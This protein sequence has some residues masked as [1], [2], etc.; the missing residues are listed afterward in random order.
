MSKTQKIGLT[1]IFFAGLAVFWHFL[2]PNIPDLDSF[3]YLGKAHLIREAGLFNDSFPWTQFS[4]IKN[5]GSSLW[6]GFGLLLVPFSYIAN[7]A[8]GIKLAGVLLTVFALFSCFWVASRHKLRWPIVWPLLMFFSAPNVTIQLLMTR[9]QTATVG[10]GILLLSFLVEGR[11]WQVL[12]TTF[13]LVWIH[14]NFAWM[15]IAIAG[16]VLLARVLV[17]KRFE[18]RKNLA[19]IT[20]VFA[21]WIARPNP[22]GAAKLFY[23]QVVKQILEKQGGLPLLFGKENFP[24]TT[25]VLLTNF[26][27]FLLLWLVCLALIVWLWWRRTLQTNPAQ[28]IL[29]ISGLILS[30]IF[31]FL[32]ILIARRAYDFW[33]AFGVI[34]IAVVISQI[35]ELVA[36]Q[37]NGDALKWVGGITIVL[38]VFLTLFSGSKTIKSLPQTYSQTYL[39]ESA[40]WLNQN[41]QPGDIVFNVHWSHFSPLFLWD[42]KNYYI[43]A[44]DPIFQY[45][46]DP[47]LYWKFHYLSA[48][49]TSSFT[50]GQPACKRSEVEDTY[51]VLKNDFHAKYLLV[52]Q[53]Y[54]PNLY[55]YLPTDSRFQKVFET[56]NEAVYLIR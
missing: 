5:Y 37:K 51:T 50:C 54:N 19:V 28:K 48:D 47:T 22:L 56:M 23:V 27:P 15:P 38:L 17:E 20:G 46:Y 14:L 25:N 1:V 3:F 53:V 8:V 31:F 55:Q 12:L 2:S 30:P 39:K 40:D 18:L 42:R 4:V 10:L 49:Q 52:S 32:S 7:A 21:G 34:I 33:I 6:F 44:L 16:S 36:R 29:A 13:F 35:M 24:L 11:S 9:P 41:S 26:L 43:N 45:N